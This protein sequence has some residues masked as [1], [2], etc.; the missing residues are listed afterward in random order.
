MK[1][2]LNL[3]LLMGLWVF[4]ATGVTAS[5]EENYY[6]VWSGTLTQM[7]V[8]GQQYEQY[9]VTLTVTPHEY[10]IDYDSLGCGGVLRL[11][12]RRGRFYRFVD[13]LNYGLKNCDNGGRTEIHF[14]NPG[15]AAFQWFDKKGVLKVEGRLKRQPQMMI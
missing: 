8:A 11:L 7:V 3:F 6:G 12:A 13:E 4:V 5:A 10:R 9:E 1:T 15:L 14:I 2:T